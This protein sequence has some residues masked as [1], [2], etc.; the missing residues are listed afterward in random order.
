MPLSAAFS[1]AMVSAIGSI[2]TAIASFAPSI[3]AAMDSIPL[4]QPR[5]TTLSPSLTS[6]SMYSR[7]MRV[8][9]CEPVPNAMPGSSDNT[10]LP[11]A[12]YSS[13]HD[14]LTSRCLPTGKG[15]YA[16]FH[17]LSHTESSTVCTSILRLPTPKPRA[18]PFSSASDALSAATA[19]SAASSSSIYAFTQGS[20]AQSSSMSAK[21]QYFALFCK[22]SAISSWP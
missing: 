15:L 17:A 16:S 6:S 8:V 4:P 22:K 12:S 19:A 7:H 14:G 3:S 20:A 21:S 9:G 11:W 2:S 5:S 10:R 18:M 13:S 1:Y